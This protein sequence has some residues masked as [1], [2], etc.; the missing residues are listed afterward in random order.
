MTPQKNLGLKNS[1]TLQL[2][3]IDPELPFPCLDPD[4]LLGVR[5]KHG[6]WGGGSIIPELIL[7][8]LPAK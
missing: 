3:G 7:F 8:R 2:Q 1:P 6:P 4:P 5:L